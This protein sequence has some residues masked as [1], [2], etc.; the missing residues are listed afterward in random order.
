[1]CQIPCIDTK[2]SVIKTISFNDVSN[3]LRK[4]I[5]SSQVLLRGLIGIS[6]TY[7]RPPYDNACGTEHLSTWRR[8]QDT[9]C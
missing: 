7:L 8:V 4:Q 5:L 2:A 6:P 3:P 9:A 1:M